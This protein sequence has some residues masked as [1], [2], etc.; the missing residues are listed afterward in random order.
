M[1]ETLFK[2]GQQR[3]EDLPE[4]RKKRFFA[5]TEVLEHIGVHL[6]G[7]LTTIKN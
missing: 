1:M 4:F 5:A 3:R 2:M 7:V 6:G